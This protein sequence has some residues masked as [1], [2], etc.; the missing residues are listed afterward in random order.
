VEAFNVLN[1]PNFANPINSLY[2][3]GVAN[4]NDPNFGVATQMLGR[5]FA[6]TGGGVSPLYQIGGPRSLQVSLKLSF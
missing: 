6:N 1:H 2:G 3:G 4:I 5:G